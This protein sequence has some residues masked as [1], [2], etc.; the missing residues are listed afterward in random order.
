MRTIFFLLAIGVGYY[1]FSQH[2][3][4][5]D[6]YPQ[7]LP[8]II[9]KFKVNHVV[10]IVPSLYDNTPDTVD[11]FYDSL[12]RDTSTY[13]NNERNSYKRYYYNDK[14]KITSIE[15]FSLS[16]GGF[17]LSEQYK[18]LYNADKSYRIAYLN[19]IWRLSDTSYFNKDGMI[20]KIGY[21]SETITYVYENKK[22]MSQKTS[23]GLPALSTVAR[24][25]YNTD[26]TL[27]FQNNSNGTR[28]A[29]RYDNS[30]KVNQV[31]YDSKTYSASC[32][33]LLWKTYKMISYIY[34]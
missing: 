3:P 22:L 16:L 14:K 26:G 12:G 33:C 28:I 30:G 21:L 1:G 23:R 25:L 32:K 20:L 31:L 8:G 24:Y 4:E 29:Y 34:Q 6:D 27:K 17:K 9:K 19:N 11:F 7:P 15:V 10:A 5:L 2:H 18:Y 13:V